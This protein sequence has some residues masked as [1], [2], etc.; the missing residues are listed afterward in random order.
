ML[1]I[2]IAALLGIFWFRGHEYWKWV[3]VLFVWMLGAQLLFA[4]G[5]TLEDPSGDGLIAHQ[6]RIATNDGNGMG[7]FAIV[8][9]IVYWGG[10]IW[11]LRKM[12]LVAKRSGQVSV[13]RKLAEAAALTVVAAVYVY[14]AFLFTGTP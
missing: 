2:Y 6:I 13:G 4:G 9:I 1:I 3:A 10:A 14:S 7:I 11:L 12:Y 8:F 5:G